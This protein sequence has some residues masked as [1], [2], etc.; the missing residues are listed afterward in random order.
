MQSSL[1]I[2]LT[3]GPVCVFSP[4]HGTVIFIEKI[5][6]IEQTHIVQTCAVWGSTVIAD[7]LLM[8]NPAVALSLNSVVSPLDIHFY[9]H[10][11]SNNTKPFMWVAGIV[12]YTWGGGSIL[13][14]QKTVPERLNDLLQAE[15]KMPDLNSNLDSPTQNPAMYLMLG[16]PRPSW[17]T[18]L[19]VNQGKIHHLSVRK[20][21][22]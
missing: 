2:S 10:C 15:Q 17:N 16:P 9:W 19:L 22:T 3:S 7:E 11:A 18:D 20:T 21:C 6:C 14:L 13:I 1:C 4:G 8:V 5:S 12:L